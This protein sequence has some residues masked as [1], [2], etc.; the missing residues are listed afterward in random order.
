MGN[1]LLLWFEGFKDTFAELG[2]EVDYLTLGEKV[3]GDWEGPSKL[4]V[5]NEEF[6][7]KLEGKILDKLEFVELNPGVG[8]LIEKIE[9]SG[10]NIG[11]LTTSKRIYVEPALRRLGVIDKI[12][13]FLAKEDVVKYKPDPEIINKAMEIIGGKKSETVMIG[14]TV[15]DILAAKRAGID[16]VLYYP[17]R[18]RKF[19]SKE[20][21]KNLGATVIIDNFEELRKF[22]V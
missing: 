9:A 4:G 2:V 10:G 19:Y 16:S 5:S 12:D 8:D 20:T 18:Y 7:K 22:L 13:V 6:I 11:V 21:Q 1:S 15:K 17:E 14:D 3:I